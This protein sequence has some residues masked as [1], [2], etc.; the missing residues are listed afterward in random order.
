MKEL[1]N[2]QTQPLVLEDGTVLAAAGSKGSVRHVESISDAD[3]R[4][5]A[6]RGLIAVR[7]VEFESTAAST[8]SEASTS[9]VSEPSQTDAT[10]EAAVASTKR[11]AKR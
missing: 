1:I 7:D 8:V 3:V 2:Q 9:A 5:L 6:D 10:S 4:R 11:E